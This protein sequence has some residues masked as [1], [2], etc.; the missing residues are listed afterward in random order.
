MQ[1]L[2]VYNLQHRLSV[3]KQYCVSFWFLWFIMST[4]FIH[5]L[6]GEEMAKECIRFGLSGRFTMKKALVEITTAFVRNNCFPKTC[7]FYTSQ[8]VQGYFP[9]QVV[10]LTDIV[11]NMKRLPNSMYQ[12]KHRCAQVCHSSALTTLLPQLH[13]T[14]L[15]W[16]LPRVRINRLWR[17]FK[18]CWEDSRTFGKNFA[19]SCQ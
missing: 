12:Q 7:Q 19:L 5:N 13:Q 11:D 1:E 2:S 6:S 17:N 8:P 3:R 14:L 18:Q 10:I 9:Y 16:K 15:Q 4:K